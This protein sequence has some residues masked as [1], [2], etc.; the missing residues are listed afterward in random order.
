MDYSTARK[1]WP[2]DKFWPKDKIWLFWS[3]K[4]GV[5]RGI[6][7]KF[8]LWTFHKLLKKQK[9]FDFIDFWLP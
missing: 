7:V 6:S 4:F 5:A 2:N 9:I 1:F 3:N 8:S